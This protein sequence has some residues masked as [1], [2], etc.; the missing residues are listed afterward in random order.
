M[1]EMTRLGRVMGPL[2]AAAETAALGANVGAGTVGSE[3]VGMA[4]EIGTLVEGT[5]AAPPHAETPARSAAS[6]KADINRGHRYMPTFYQ[7]PAGA[8]PLPSPGTVQC[9]PRP[10]IKLA[11][12]YPGGS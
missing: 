1:A 2:K 6:V 10:T 12:P 11:C 9:R 4:V 3:A 7:K 8:H 5:D